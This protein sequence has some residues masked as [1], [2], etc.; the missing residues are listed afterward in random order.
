M[1]RISDVVRSIYERAH[2]ERYA[3][4]LYHPGVVRNE[5]WNG[6]TPFKVLYGS[7]GSVIVDPPL[8]KGDILTVT[9]TYKP[10]LPTN[11]MLRRA[12]MRRRALDRRMWIRSMLDLSRMQLQQHVLVI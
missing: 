7:T 8:N 11:P 3:E 6:T 12:E 4:R 5:K 2:A 9:F 10:A 1:R